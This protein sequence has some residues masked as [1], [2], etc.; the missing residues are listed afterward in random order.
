MER[1]TMTGSIFGSCNCDWGCPCN[2]D[3]APSYGHCD[4]V[5]VFSVREGRYGDDAL[6]G[7]QFAWA[8][9]SPG[10]LHKGNVTAVLIVDERATPEQR[11]ALDQLW[12]GAAG[13]PFDILHSVTSTWLDT[14]SAP[15]DLELAGIGSRVKIGGKGEIYDLAQ[16]RV[17]NPVT[18]EDEEL[19]LDKP[20]GF[21]SKRS[22]LGMAERAVFS[23]DGLSWDT[24]GKYAEYGEFEYAGGT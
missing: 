12:S 20:T 14:I 13:L 17:K 18:G 24:S 5:Y 2:F 3:V 19:Y 21:T 11:D 10:P 6:D 9:H 1:W 16:S 7:L 4:G 15:F 23:C 22:E 8:A